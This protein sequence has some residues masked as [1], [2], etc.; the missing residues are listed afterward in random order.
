MGSGGLINNSPTISI[1]G[2]AAFDVS[3]VSPYSLVQTLSA[4]QTGTAYVTG[5]LS[6]GGNTIDMQDG[7][8]IGT[9]AVSGGL[10]L[11]GSTLR[12][13]VG[14]GNADEITVGAAASML[15]T[16]IINVGPLASV[17]AG[18]YT[19]ISDPSGGLTGTFQ[20]SST[21][22]SAN[23]QS[24]DLSLVNSGGTA[25]LLSVT[26]PLP[27][28]TL[29]FALGS[30]AATVRAGVQTVN[31]VIGNTSSGGSSLLNYT[32]TVSGGTGGSGTRVAGDAGAVAPITGNYLALAGT[33]SVTVA[34]RT[35]PPTTARSRP[36][37]R[38]RPTTM[39][40]RPTRAGR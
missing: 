14:P 21:T 40:K 11:N 16:N 33:H 15:G 27:P 23:G 2:G 17:G 13:N 5:G 1:A 26:T 18:T 12:F 9:L 7:S 37:S 28:A 10:N 34:H 22:L 29:A 38:R 8:N 36:P 30:N 32:Y 39:P 19:L 31:M 35:R 6:V 4:K 25:E 24:Y 20:L 3:V